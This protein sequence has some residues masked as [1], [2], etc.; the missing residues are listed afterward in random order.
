MW[1]LITLS[2]PEPCFQISCNTGKLNKNGW[3]GQQKPVIGI[4]PVFVLKNNKYGIKPTLAL[5]A[6]HQNLLTTGTTIATCQTAGTTTPTGNNPKP[7]W[8]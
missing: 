8:G 5:Q 7:V 4:E 2:I 6:K 3:T 1:S